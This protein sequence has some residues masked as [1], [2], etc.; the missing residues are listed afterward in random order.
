MENENKEPKLKPVTY[1]TAYYTKGEQNTAQ[2]VALLDAMQTTDDPQKLK[3]I[4]GFQRVAEVYRT[5][6]KMSM[7]REYHDAL[8]RAGISFDFIVSGL[9]T[10]AETGYKDADKVNALKVLLK[11]LG[12][13]KY[14]VS[15][16]PSGSTWEEMI[17]KNVNA[18]EKKLSLPTGD[19]IDIPDSVEEEESPD[20]GDYDV[21][22]PEAP[23]FIKRMEEKEDDMSSTLYG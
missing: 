12:M 17:L 7:R 1:T 5:L 20:F 11:S 21:V 15:D 14:D 23:E 3:A 2:Q 16:T 8:A 22:V 18:P 10:V 6:D 9:K 4:V 13:E 19:E